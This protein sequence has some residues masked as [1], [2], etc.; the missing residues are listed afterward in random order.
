MGIPLVHGAIAGW[1]GQVT[2][3]FPGEDNLERLY[4]RS[5]EAKGIEQH[6]GNPS[7]TPAI[8]ASLE[9]AEVCK[10]LLG[11][12]TTLR[13]RNLFVDLLDMSF[14]E[15]ACDSQDHAQRTTGGASHRVLTRRAPERNASP[16]AP[17][18]R[19]SEGWGFY[20]CCNV[21]LERCVVALVSDRGPTMRRA[22][23]SER[24]AGV[25]RPRSVVERFRRRRLKKA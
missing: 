2:T 23:S 12:G 24:P 16:G 7:F 1:Y 11:M 4:S 18:F 13:G 9:T 21:G 19:A 8:V 5:L 20:R 6:L 10:I 25:I 17:S 14:E 22:A 15:V 3:Q